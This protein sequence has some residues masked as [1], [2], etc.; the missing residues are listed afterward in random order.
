MYEIIQYFTEQ[1]EMIIRAI[2][3]SSNE[4]IFNDILY[5]IEHNYSAPLKLE[6][7]ASLF[8]YN[9][10]Y[11]GKLFS[12]KM[13]QSFNSYLDEVRIKHSVELLEDTHLKVYEIAT[14][15]GYSNVNYFHY[16]FKKLKGISPVEFRKETI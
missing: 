3:N 14:K 10:S 5:Y 7:I 8:G 4:S 9:S 1:F 16:K 6:T 11:L 2:G 15:V 13:N 12:Q